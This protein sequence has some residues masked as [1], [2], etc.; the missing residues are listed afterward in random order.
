MVNCIN[1][2]PDPYGLGIVH[3]DNGV[4]GVD[5]SGVGLINCTEE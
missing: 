1:N 2:T 3:D 4:V 5:V